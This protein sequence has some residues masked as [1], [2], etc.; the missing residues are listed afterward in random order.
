M[1][2]LFT[3][4]DVSL[5]NSK[6]RCA[7]IHLFGLNSVFQAHET[8]LVWIEEI[9]KMWPYSILIFQMTSPSQ[10]GGLGK[11]LGL[12]RAHWSKERPDF[13]ETT[14]FSQVIWILALCQVGH[15]ELQFQP[16]PVCFLQARN[17][18]TQSPKC[19]GVE[20]VEIWS[21]PMWDVEKMWQFIDRLTPVTLH[22]NVILPQELW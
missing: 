7:Q 8:E 14:T 17:G 21:Q 18:L 6:P 10:K 1:V 16:Q 12:R 5:T 9:W 3:W 22:A 4:K 19:P 13:L 11:D 20:V 2:C 15:I